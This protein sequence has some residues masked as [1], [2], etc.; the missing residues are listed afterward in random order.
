[1]QVQLLSWFSDEPMPICHPFLS[2][3]G[4]RAVLLQRSGA[5]FLLFVSYIQALLSSFRIVEG[6]CEDI[7]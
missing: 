3:F 6:T 5:S 1:M 7:A 4:V 2:L